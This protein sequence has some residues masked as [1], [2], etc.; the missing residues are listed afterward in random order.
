MPRDLI[1]A[2][3]PARLASYEAEWSRDAEISPDH[4]SST[5]VVSL[6]VWQIALSSAWYET[7]SYVEAVLRNAIDM[8]LRDWNTAN[9]C[10]ED[11]LSDTKAPL[12]SLVSKAATN[13]QYRADQARIRRSPSHPRF[14]APVCF[15]DKVSQLDFGDL[16]RLFP[17][18]P[19]SNRDQT[20]TGFNG[21]ENLWIH[22][23]SNAFPHLDEADLQKWEGRYPDNIPEEVKLGYAVG[24][25]IDKLRRLRNRIS[26]HEQTFRVN[27]LQRLEDVSMIVGGISP[28]I[29]GD[30]EKLDRVRR[31][32]V[33]RPRS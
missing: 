9:G 26:H 24:H 25:A 15:D 3:N 2:L 27:H 14:E 1:A 32:L 28:A 31:G 17:L 20:G 6:Y 29:S 21:R 19:P 5:S 4:V 23:L 7:L 12:R 18:K 10:S 22:G 33:M 16:V 8:A 13:A 30:L 11:W